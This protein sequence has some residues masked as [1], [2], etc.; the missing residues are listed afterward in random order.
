MQLSAPP[1]LRIEISEPVDWRKLPEYVEQ[2]TK[3]LWS[4]WKIYLTERGVLPK[5]LYNLLLIKTSEDILKW[6]SKENTWNTLLDKII[7][8]ITSPTQ[9]FHFIFK[10]KP[11]S[12]FG[13]PEGETVVFPAN[14]VKEIVSPVVYLWAGKLISHGTLPK[15]R[16][17]KDKLV[18]ERETDTVKFKFDDNF[19]HLWILSD[20]PR[21][22]LLTAI[23]IVDNFIH[24]LTLFYGIRGKIDES[25]K[26]ASSMVFTYEIVLGED[27]YGRQI[28]LPSSL[29][30]IKGVGYDIEALK[31]Q[32]SECIECQ[33]L[34]ND[35]TLRKSLEYFYHA[36]FLDSIRREIPHIGH[37]TAT[38]HHMYL[39]SDIILNL[40]KS[41]ST[42]VGDPSKDKNYQSRYK[43]YG[44]KYEFW[45]EKIERLRQIRNDWDVAHYKLDR[46]KLEKLNE[47]IDDAID[48]TR[49][50]ILRYVEYLK[51]AK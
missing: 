14:Q 44:I 21:N 6:L 8:L 11:E 38:E 24:L 40:Y 42:I 50:V 49:K 25:N 2:L 4:F 26:Y 7:K 43:K 29:F 19:M 20:N 15:Y 33:E 34:M 16:E 12:V 36:L 28:P 51:S 22:A 27:Q 17:E 35:S 37:T 45:K 10:L 46:E 18:L 23:E 1:E 39:L 41:V 48:V 5:D 31:E 13:L 32:I 30:Q 9:E 47:K 3:Y